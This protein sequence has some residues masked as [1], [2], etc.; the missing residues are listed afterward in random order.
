PSSD[1][2]A[3]SPPLGRGPLET[4][5]DSAALGLDEGGLACHAPTP[6]CELHPDV[7]FAR[8]NRVVQQATR[9]A[10]NPSFVLT[11]YPHRI[12][13][14]QYLM[15]APALFPRVAASLRVDVIEL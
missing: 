11:K 4:R 1:T 6:S 9:G 8:W 3:G 5:R 7:P 10:P 14:L 12:P 13:A 2:I 15:G